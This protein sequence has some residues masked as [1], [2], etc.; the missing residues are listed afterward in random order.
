MTSY[1]QYLED[2][3]LMNILS[4]Y[5]GGDL[6]FS[7]IRYI[8][9]GA[10]DPDFLSV[11]KIFYDMGA[12]GINI[13]PLKDSYKALVDKRRYD[14]NLN[15]ALGEKPG[16]ATMSVDGMGSSL[17]NPREGL[18][19]QE[20][21]VATLSDIY[22]HFCKKWKDI[23]FVKIDVEGYEKNVLQGVS[24]WDTF[25][26]WIFCMESTLPG[27]DIPCFEDWEYILLEHDYELVH[28]YKINRFYADKRRG[29]RFLNLEDIQNL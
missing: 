4:S 17:S 20:V 7:D 11:T 27:T 21:I 24:D 2:K 29:L 26:P 13:E 12:S 1:A 6:E 14:I 5:Q 22:K 16:H 23:H 28:E 18:P 3:I 10:N 19:T 15:I 9:V 25:R 8:D